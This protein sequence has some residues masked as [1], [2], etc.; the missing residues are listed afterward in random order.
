MNPSPKT[1]T[2][3]YIDLRS[4][5]IIPPLNQGRCD[6]PW[7]N[8]MLKGSA[9]YILNGEPVVVRE[10][11]AVYF[12]INDV[13]GRKEQKSTV[14]YLSIVYDTNGEEY[15]LDTLIPIL[16]GNPKMLVEMLQ[17]YYFTGQLGDESNRIAS[18]MIFWLLL[19]EL[20]ATCVQKKENTAVRDIRNFIQKNWAEGITTSDVAKAMSLNA[21][22]CNTLYKS[23]SGETVG[24]YISRLRLNHAKSKLSHSNLSVKKIAGECGYK[25]PYYFS[26]FFTKKE[27]ISPSE[28]RRRSNVHTSAKNSP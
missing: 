17:N 7:M 13:V 16:G 27:G 14:R 4:R 9:E 1:P 3:H 15:K 5:A 12:K 11:Y 24:E 21:S 23:K 8:I 20:E 26:T 19:R 6:R 28:F 18:E 2:I 10:G 22:Y 25:D